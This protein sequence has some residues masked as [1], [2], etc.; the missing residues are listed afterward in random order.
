[1]SNELN[2]MFVSDKD[3]QTNTLKSISGIDE[4]GNLKTTPADEAI[5][6]NQFFKVDKNLNPFEN[7]FKNFWTQFKN[8]GNY[9]FFRFKE[10]EIHLVN[11]PGEQQKHEVTKE[12]EKKIKS[13]NLNPD[14]KIDWKTLAKFGIT[15][16]KLKENGSLESMLKGYG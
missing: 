4:K 2:I 15:P 3:D 9:K 7:F 6:Q 10:D 8:P 5:D 12:V 11:Q 16:E 13:L 1:M 14:E